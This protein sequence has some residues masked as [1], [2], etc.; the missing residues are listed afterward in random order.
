MT[1]LA[2]LCKVVLPVLMLFF[3]ATPISIATTY[4]VDGNHTS[5]SDSNPGTLELP[6]LTIQHAAETVVAGD[7]VYIRGGIYNEHVHISNEGNATDGHIVFS[8]YPDEVAIIE[9]TG[10]TESQ[11]GIIVDK[12]YIK[13]FGLEIL[14]WNENGIW[15]ERAGYI[16]IS[17]C[18]VYNVGNGIGMIEGV[19]DF[20]LNRVE[21]HHFDL[22]GFDASPYGTDCYNGTFNDCIAHTGRDHDQNV[23]GFAIGHGTQHDFTFNRCETY[24]VYDGFDIGE[25][26]GRRHI[27][28]VLNR[29]SS[30]DCWNDGYKLTGHGKLVNCLGYNNYNANVAVYWDVNAGTADLYNCTF[31]DSEVFNVWVENSSDSLLM[32]NC[33]LAGGDNICLGFEQ[34]DV[35]RYKGDYNLFH[36]D[37]L[38]RAFV[39]GY[40]DE[41]SLDQLESGVWTTYS[42]QDA[43]SLISQSDVDIFTDPSNFNLHLRE[44]SN[45]IDNGTS[46]GAPSDDFDGNPRP[47]GNG[48]D[49]GAY[50]YQGPVGVFGVGS[51]GRI[52]NTSVLFQNYPNPFNSSTT[53][54][55]ILNEAAFVRLNIYDILGHE[56]DT[57]IHN[58]QDAG[59]HSL[60]WAS[61]GLPS[62]VYFYRIE[63]GGFVHTKKL[64]LQK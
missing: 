3:V 44:T 16:E 52:P 2:I 29:C 50:E 36:N 20:V 39:V 5:A 11:N 58:H 41:F 15:I 48:Y 10:V 18:E 49:M 24:D 56:I 45:A 42:G 40:E 27:N 22:Y 23:D 47:I 30:H 31:F 54:R 62:G 4:Y 19:H 46:V 64:I 37:D 32:Y 60:N 59:E 6:W 38:D 14:N 9:G 13:L 63:T 53:F 8:S 51:E 34:R 7:T 17:H 25:N 12:S 55:Y 61:T 26:E 1:R 21:M 43:H 28:I 35:S 57:I 33:I